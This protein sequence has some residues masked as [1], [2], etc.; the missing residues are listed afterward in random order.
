MKV[1]GFVRLKEDPTLYVR[2]SE[3]SFVVVVVYVDN[4]LISED[5]NLP[6]NLVVKHFKKTLEA[7]L[8]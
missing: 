8:D 4:I 5:I 1:S 6:L 3:K 7:R 2:N